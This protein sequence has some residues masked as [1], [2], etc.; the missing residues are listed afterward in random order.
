MIR[1]E[2]EDMP[3]RP[4][5]KNSFSSYDESINPLF[6]MPD[7]SNPDDV[8][9]HMAKLLSEN[10][11]LKRLQ[12]RDKIIKRSQSLQSVNHDQVCLMKKT[13]SA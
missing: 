11:E 9:L 5:S 6:K 10:E 7:L 3:D 4:I 12:Q 2:I 13:Y 1:S 8:A